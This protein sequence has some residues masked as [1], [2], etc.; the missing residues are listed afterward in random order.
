[1]ILNKLW[2]LLIISSMNTEFLIKI[3]GQNGI[4][5]QT[6]LLYLLNV[7]LFVSIKKN[8]RSMTII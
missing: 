7:T 5:P 6:T 4:F 8:D 2:N 1:M 3:G